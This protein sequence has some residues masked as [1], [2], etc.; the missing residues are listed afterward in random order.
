MIDNNIKPDYH[1]YV[2]NQ[3]MKPVS[4]I[5][6]LRIEEIPTFKK[7]SDY[8][9]QKLDQQI[10]NGT[11]EES[12]IKK[13]TNEKQRDTEELLFWDILYLC[14]SQKNGN[15]SITNWFSK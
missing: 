2:T 8:Y 10:N 3:I 1:F 15:Q 6:A 12:A 7:A 13:I 9:K 5:F 14:E 4:Q 11:E